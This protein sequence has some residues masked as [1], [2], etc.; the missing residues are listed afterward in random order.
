M[1]TIEQPCGI[2]KSRSMSGHEPIDHLGYHRE[3]PKILVEP[4]LSGLTWQCCTH[5]LDRFIFLRTP[6]MLASFV[7]YLDI[8]RATISATFATLLCQAYTLGSS[9]TYRVAYR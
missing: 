9:R 5:A 1:L 8:S 7:R 3:P 4:P 2:V 6:A